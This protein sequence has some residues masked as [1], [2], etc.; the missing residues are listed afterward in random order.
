[1]SLK[2]DV[3]GAELEVLAGALNCIKTGR[4]KYIQVE[5]SVYNVYENVAVSAVDRFLTI[6]SYR[7]KKEF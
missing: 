2:I 3:E 5:S 1:M 7:R 4:I 6:N